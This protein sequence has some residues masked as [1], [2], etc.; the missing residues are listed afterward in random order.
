MGQIK[1]S[2]FT[3]VPDI[4]RLEKWLSVEIPL[5][6]V[7]YPDSVAVLFT[8]NVHCIKETRLAQLRLL[9]LQ[10]KPPKLNQLEVI[11][12][13]KNVLF[14]FRKHQGFILLKISRNHL[15]IGKHQDQPS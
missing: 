3:I 15:D 14:L 10:Q 4:I 5:S 13:V 2:N 12:M 11:R 9:R 1:I 8:E 7:V 6:M